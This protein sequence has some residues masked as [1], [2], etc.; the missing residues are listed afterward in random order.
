MIKHELRMGV[1]EKPSYKIT[2]HLQLDNG[3]VRIMGNDGTGE[4][5]VLTIYAT[6]RVYRH[7]NSGVEG[8]DVDVKG[9][10]KEYATPQEAHSKGKGY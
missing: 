5:N 4:R 1:I 10:I 9:R 8:L 6:G 2:W 3:R 7:Q